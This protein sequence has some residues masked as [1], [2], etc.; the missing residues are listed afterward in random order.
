MKNYWQ[1][2]GLEERASQDEIKK[3]YKKYD[4]K[5][6]PDLNVNHEFL[7]ERFKEIQDSYETLSLQQ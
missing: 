4:K 2:L 1:I 6:H 7:K 5:L 3:A